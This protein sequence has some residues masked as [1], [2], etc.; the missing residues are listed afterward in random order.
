MR[1]K[2]IFLKLQLLM[3]AAL[4]LLGISSSFA[5]SP[6]VTGTVTDS[7]GKGIENVSVKIKGTSIGT[8]TQANGS[9]S[10]VAPASAKTIVFSSVGYN[11]VEMSIA[12]KKEFNISLTHNNENLSDIVVIGY[13]AQSKTK[14]TAAVSK[15]NPEE[16]R[17]TNNPN[18]V[19]AIQGKIA[20][21]SVPINT[22]Q[23]GSG[24]NNILIRGGTK[25]NVY[26]TNIGNA[27]G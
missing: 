15:L 13:T 22:G 26:G 18:P 12:G 14:I 27:G 20:G 6:T 17:N 4:L 2:L 3:A 25:L 19:Q 1:R 8:V 16:L 7:S 23:P 11:P 21:V 24:A 9:F 10:L 5:Q